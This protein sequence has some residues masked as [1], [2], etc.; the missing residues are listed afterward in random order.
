MTKC[1]R[2]NIYYLLGTKS[3]SASDRWKQRSSSVWGKIN[4]LEYT[5]AISE[6]RDVSG[7]VLF[8]HGLSS[9][10]FGDHVSKDSHHGG[11]SVVQFNIK[12]AGLFFGV[13]DVGSEVTN[14]VVSVVL[15]GRHPCEF[16]KGEEGEDLKKTGVGDGT[17]SI[18]S[19]WDIREFKVLG[20][21]EVSIENNV[22]VV[23]DDTDNGSHGNTSVLTFDSTTT[24]KRLGLRFEPSKRII[25]SQRG[26]DTNLEFIDVQRGGGLC[27]LGRGE[28]GRRGDEGGKDGRLHFEFIFFDISARNSRNRK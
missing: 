4:C 21:G 16:D 7:R 2:L 24:F 6:R 18:N 9:E 1:W 28:S 25:D 11:T 8:E 27:L 5:L 14:S 17:D 20:S 12:L 19:G 22:V 15:G 3:I 23:D 10:L 26:S 13:L